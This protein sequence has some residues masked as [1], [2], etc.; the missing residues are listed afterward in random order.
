MDTLNITIKA[1]EQRIKNLSKRASKGD[2]AAQRVL[3]QQIARL[4]NL[5]EE[6]DEAVMT[7]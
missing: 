6:W 1:T 5:R 7:V 3:S 4:A 2:R